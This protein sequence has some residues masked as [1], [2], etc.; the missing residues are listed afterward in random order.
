MSG[1]TSFWLAPPRHSRV[2]F[3]VVEK[4]SRLRSVIERL[5]SIG[6]VR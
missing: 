6:R 3:D 5:K 4:P 2:F 1:R